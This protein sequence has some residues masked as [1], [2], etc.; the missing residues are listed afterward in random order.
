MNLETQEDKTETIGK[1]ETMGKI[2]SIIKTIKKSS[3]NKQC[4]KL[5]CADEFIINGR[6]YFIPDKYITNDFLPIEYKQLYKIIFAQYLDLLITTNKVENIKNI[7]DI[8]IKTCIN[9]V[10]KILAY[11]ITGKLYISN[12]TTIEK[13]ILE[14]IPDYLIPKLNPN[15]VDKIE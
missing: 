8:H 6:I 4:I 13:K 2:K 1:T 3:T 11:I 7:L 5:K 10:E 9:S 15:I 12:L 14:N